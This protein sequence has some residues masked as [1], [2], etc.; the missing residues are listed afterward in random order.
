MR[1]Q[2]SDKGVK[3]QGNEGVRGLKAMKGTT[4]ARE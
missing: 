2:R 4:R 3:E 1:E